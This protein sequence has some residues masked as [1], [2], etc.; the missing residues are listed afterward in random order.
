MEPHRPFQLVPDEGDPQRAPRKKK[1]RD[2]LPLDE[3]WLED[4]AVRSLARSDQS[5]HRLI[6]TLERK[7]DERAARTEE[8]PETVRAA[9]PGIVD[10]LVD[11]ALHS[12]LAHEIAE[13]PVTR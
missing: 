9:I 4:E 13:A 6:E 2:A 1:R 7:L 11:R 12:F 5:R 8:D 3:K 10:Q